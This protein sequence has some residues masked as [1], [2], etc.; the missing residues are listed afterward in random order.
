MQSWIILI[1]SSSLHASPVELELR[2]L[3]L[4]LLDPFSATFPR[5]YALSVRTAS[6]YGGVSRTSSSE[7]MLVWSLFGSI[8]EQ[9]NTPDGL[10]QSKARCIRLAQ[11]VSFEFRFEMDKTEYSS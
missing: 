10:V 7:F 3:Q 8:M 9:D 11:A 2:W 6:Q 5:D 4:V 1:S